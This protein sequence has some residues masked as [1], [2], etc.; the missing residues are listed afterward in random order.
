[1]RKQGRLNTKQGGKLHHRSYKHSNRFSK[2]AKRGFSDLPQ[3][4]IAK[5][6]ASLIYGAESRKAYRRLIRASSV[7]KWW[8]DALWPVIED[9]K[10]VKCMDITKAMS[11]GK[12]FKHGL[13]GFLRSLDNA[14]TMFLVAAEFGAPEG[15]VDAGKIYWER[16]EA[17]K[18]LGWYRRAAELG[19]RNAQCNLGIAC[20]EV[21][22]PILEE[23]VKWLSLPCLKDNARAQYQLGVCLRHIG[24]VE[25][26]ARRWLRAAEGGYVRAMYNVSQCY[27]HGE[28]LVQCDSRAR[29]WMKLAADRGHSKAQHYYQTKRKYSIKDLFS[30][31]LAN[32]YDIGFKHSRPDVAE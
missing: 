11:L 6:G 25:N 2:P 32:K 14:L 27:E 9:E 12:Q 30:N 4:L 8:R 5:I 1:M 16:G 13:G 10:Y 17:D 26:A 23:A 3:D 20:M 15:M 29:K 22:P 21:Q 31:G 24:D 28:G 7:C 19:N 18:A